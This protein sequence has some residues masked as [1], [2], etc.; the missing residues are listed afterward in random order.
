M[1]RAARRR[2]R[3]EAASI[4]L[5][6][7]QGAGLGRRVLMAGLAYLAVRGV[8]VVDLS[9]DSENPEGIALYD[10]VGFT[11]RTTTEWHEKTLRSSQP[12]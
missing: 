7:H 12:R 6:E 8:E 11:N 3:G 10:S 1:T 4:V 2:A 9:V 5:P